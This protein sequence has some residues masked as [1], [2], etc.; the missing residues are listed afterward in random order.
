MRYKII[1]SYSINRIIQEYPQK[2][3]EIKI[4]EDDIIHSHSNTVS[5]GSSHGDPTA[6]KAFSLSGDKRL[7][8][9]REEQEAVENAL[10]YIR[11]MDISNSLEF[12]HY[13][14]WTNQYRFYGAMRKADISQRYA[15]K[16]IKGMRF[17]VAL[18][19]GKVKVF[20]K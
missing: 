15:D 17:A 19:L 6:Y 12:I 8:R 11:G 2:Q 10:Q 14:Y 18:H 13:Y 3:N 4:L 7:N 9:L 20:Q 1:D 16:I 5:R